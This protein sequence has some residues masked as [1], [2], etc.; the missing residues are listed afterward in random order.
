MHIKQKQELLYIL[1]VCKC[2]SLIFK[3]IIDTTY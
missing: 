3:A 1:V 2:P